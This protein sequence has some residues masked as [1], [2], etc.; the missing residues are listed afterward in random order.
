MSLWPW[1]TSWSK[2]FWIYFWITTWWWREVSMPNITSSWGRWQTSSGMSLRHQRRRM[3]RRRGAERGMNGPSS[4]LRGPFLPSKWLN[5]KR[6]LP[7]LKYISK[8]GTSSRWSRL[9]P[10]SS[11]HKSR[12]LD[13]ASLTA[14]YDWIANNWKKFIIFNYQNNYPFENEPS[15]PYSSLPKGNP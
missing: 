10:T 15:Q 4:L 7:K 13:F 12:N 8:I 14:Q 6:M 2:Y 5:C 9:W 3:K 11:K 1:S